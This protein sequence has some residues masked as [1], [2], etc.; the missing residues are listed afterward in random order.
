MSA[1]AKTGKRSQYERIDG[2]YASVPFSVLNSTVYRQLNGGAVRLL[3][4]LAMQYN[5]GN[6]GKLVACDSYLRPLGWTSKA[7]VSRSLNELLASGIITQTRQGRRAHI[8]SW[9]A[10]CWYGLHVSQGLDI[11]PALYRKAQL[12][13]YPQTFRPPK[14]KANHVQ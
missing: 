3:L 14:M 9:Y 4:D 6:N 11:N 7:S 10:L 1:H 13:Q 12:I 5:G 2:R 8:A